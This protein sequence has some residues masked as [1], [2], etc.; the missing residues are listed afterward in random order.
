MRFIVGVMGPAKAKKKDKGEKS[1]GDKK[2][3]KKDKKDDDKKDKNNTF[4][5]MRN[6][7]DNLQD[8]GFTVYLATPNLTDM[9]DGEM[10]IYASTTSLGQ[11]ALILRQGTTMYV[12][13]NW[14]TITG[15]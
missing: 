13:P 9:K 4:I 12:S 11:V 6:I 5:E 7:Y 10:G 14:R 15:R 3:G 8:K 1:D 2:G